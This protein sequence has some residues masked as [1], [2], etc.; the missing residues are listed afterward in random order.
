MERYS[1]FYFGLGHWCTTCTDIR[2]YYTIFKTIHSMLHAVC[3]TVQTIAFRGS[4]NMRSSHYFPLLHWIY[5]GYILINQLP[6]FLL[7]IRPYVLPNSYSTYVISSSNCMHGCCRT[8]H[9][10]SHACTLYNIYVT[11]WWWKTSY[12]LYTCIYDIF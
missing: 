8:F 4:N 3:N 5:C 1:P 7:I 9:S 11:G 2:W 6:L 10:Y 12:I